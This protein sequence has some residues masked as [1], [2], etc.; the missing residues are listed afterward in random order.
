MKEIYLV[1]HAQTDWNVQRIIQGCEADIPLN[2][3]GENQAKIT[4]HYL[5]KFRSQINFDSIL[6]SPLIRASRTAN[7]IKNILEIDVEIEI[8]EELTELKK[9]ILSGMSNKDYR[10]RKL[11]KH[12]KQLEESTIDPIE[13]YIIKNSHI[14][15]DNIKFPHYNLH[16]V[17]ELDE[18]T[19]IIINKLINSP[20]NKILVI[21]H[22]GTLDYLIK[23]LFRLNHL[24]FGN[25]S[26]GK[27]CSICCIKYDDN[28]FHMISPQNTEHLALKFDL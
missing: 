23:L 17:S 19:N 12:H 14:I 3:H 8:I 18:S 5:K 10:L 7:I 2:D 26:N 20:H 4:G 22:S 25:F 1:R 11:D 16:P 28:G 24:P 6:T 9:G 21:S 27:N 13:K 15:N